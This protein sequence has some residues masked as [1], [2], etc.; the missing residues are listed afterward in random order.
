MDKIDKIKDRIGVSGLEEKDRK[1]LFDK[2][3]DAGGKVIDEKERKRRLVIDREKQ[4]AVKDKIE[5]KQKKTK[6]QT[7]RKKAPPK[8]TVVKVKKTKNES[9]LSRFFTRFIIKLRLKFMKIAGFDGLFFNIKFLERF[10]NIYKPSLLEIQMIHFD[11]FKKNS[12]VGKKI[13]DRL[14]KMRPVFYEVAESISAIYDNITISQIVDHYKNF[15]DIPKSVSELKQPLMDIFKKLYV[16]KPYENT[17]LNSFEKALS[18][19]ASMIKD[20][21]QSQ[22][23][24]R[25]KIK[26]GLYNIFHKLYPRL[27]WLFCFY[28]DEIFETGDPEIEVLLGI[29]PEDKPGRRRL[30]K[31]NI[32][33]SADTRSEKISEAEED[34]NKDPDEDKEIPRHIKEGLKILYKLDLPQLRKEYDKSDSFKLLS[35]KDKILISYL[36]FH[37]FDKEYSW[38]FT[39]NKIKYKAEFGHRG[40]LD[41]RGKMQ[42]LYDQ[43]RKCFDS[44]KDYSD[45][46]SSFIKMSKDKPISS[47]QYFQYSK[48]LSDLEKKRIQIAQ[49][50]RNTLKTYLDNVNSIM[51]ELVDD[52][53]GE[54]NFIENYDEILEFIPQIEGEK[55]LNG[56]RVIDALNIVYNY[57]SAFIYRLDFGGDLSGS[58]EFK[59]EE[60]MK[61]PAIETDHTEKTDNE[62]ELTGDEDRS[63]LDELDDIL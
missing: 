16:L 41:R 56:K 21:A 4:K 24:Q 46:S 12:A 58:L 38:I 29:K 20:K 33:G 47:S 63:I 49:K 48:R 36:L 14:D 43:M 23:Q 30:F 31:S 7:L 62:E 34:Q 51:K 53:N 10:N 8:K 28:N 39:T 3:V 61:N 45:I 13:I 27:Y 18:I 15:P 42:D 11:I 52:L 37:E 54:K 60:F 32:A 25:K 22:P 9:A 55:K 2:F 1:K 19:K 57:I 6:T 50:T 26:N 5:R 35:I 59:D 17:I 44:F 40:K